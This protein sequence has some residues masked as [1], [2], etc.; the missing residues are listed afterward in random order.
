MLYR[1]LRSFIGKNGEGPVQRSGRAGVTI[2]KRLSPNNKE[3]E[4]AQLPAPLRSIPVIKGRFSDKLF[5]P[6]PGA[7][8][9]VV[10]YVR[11]I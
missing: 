4:R 6:H 2:G 7:R 11:F 5:H 10:T 3:L 9:S 1:G 8:T